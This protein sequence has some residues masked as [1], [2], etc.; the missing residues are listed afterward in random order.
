MSRS[1]PFRAPRHPRLRPFVGAGLVLLL[2]VAAGLALL[3][4]CGRR[5][6]GNSVWILGVDG[7]DWDFLEPLMAAGDLPNLRRLRDE[8]AWGTLFADEPL[9]SPILWTTL[10]TGHT[11]D[12]HGVTWFMTDAA[13]GG[14][15]PVSSR[16]R[17]VRAIWEIASERGLRAGV[18]GW[19][20]TWP[21]DRLAN[22]FV[23]SDALG[24]HSFGITG[25]AE[26]T[27]GLAW[28]AELADRALQAIPQ[29]SSWSPER[30]REFVRLPGEEIARRLAAEGPDGTLGQLQQALASADGYTALAADLAR[31]QR[32]RL[33]A[34]YYEGTDGVQH[35]FGAQAPPRLPWVSE[36]DQAA[37][38]GAVAAYYRHQDR[39]LGELLAR[40]GPRTTVLVVSDHGFRWGDER[41]R[42]AGQGIAEADEDHMPDGVY[43]VH[44]PGVA[45]KGPG[46]DAT[47]YDIVPSVL[48]LLGL[49]QARDLSGRPLAC[50]QP[51]GGGPAPVAT[52]ETTP[53]V[54]AAE[55]AGGT[56]AG[57]ALERTLRTLGYVA[58]P[59]DAPATAPA[60]LDTTDLEGRVNLAV[61]LRKQRR[62]EEAERELKAVL[63][64]SPRHVLARANLGRTYG[65]SGRLAEAE[66]VFRELVREQPADLESWDDLGR[67]C[68]MQ[69]RLPEAIAAWE[70]GLALQPDWT[71]GLAGLGL[72][73]HRSGRG[74]EALA[75]LDR[76]VA[77]DSHHADARLN[78]GLVRAAAGRQAEAREDLEAAARLAPRNAQAVL[79][80]SD[81]MARGGDPEGALRTLEE[82]KRRLGG[83]PQLLA[84]LG[85]QRLARGDAAAALPDLAAAA[86]ALPQD[87][88]VQG[89]YGLALAMGGQ[90][91]RA[92]AVFETIVKQQPAFAPARG[93][94]GALYA[95]LGRLPEAEQ[96]LR[97]AVRLAPRDP[98]L[99]ANLGRLLQMAGRDAEAQRE[100]QEAQ[101]L[102]RE[103]APGA[104]DGR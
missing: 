101:R 80:L 28:P 49:P 65:E 104:P 13:D 1:T 103:R 35:L 2:L 40:R 102:A 26:G 21:A 69:G 43:I 44:G 29:P 6:D 48:A 34:V 52:Y 89:N 83:D 75:A 55:V 97:E 37:F 72:A 32:P 4:G 46:P 53:R 23:V 30:L 84:A 19:W 7:A 8:G 45:K 85:A 60:G 81:V 98:D 99:R 11:P 100:L 9:L 31:E 47:Q 57:A 18:I 77:L 36:A 79:A 15:T 27:E 58:G 71:D 42:S 87:V 92:A 14:K 10:A 63:A 94:L 82:A 5:D 64:V 22:G 61:V 90:V 74:R 67:A 51:A 56:A 3:G 50:L 25:R 62:Y 33:L 88:Q 95:Q 96:Q 68:A 12:A 17:K 59:G 86:A 76:A 73:L 39:L 16:Q 70:R 20:A 93:Q 78:R 91:A 24:W 54:P 41:L 38:G 66:A